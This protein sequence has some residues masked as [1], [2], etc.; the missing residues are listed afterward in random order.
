MKLPYGYVVGTQGADGDGFDV[1]LGPNPVAPYVWVV[2]QARPDRGDTT[3][4]GH[5]MYDESKAFLGFDDPHEVTAAFLEHYDDVRFFGS[6]EQMPVSEFKTKV[7]STT[8]Y[9]KDGVLKSASASAATSGKLLRPEILLTAQVQKASLHPILAFEP[10]ADRLP[11]VAASGLNI[12]LGVPSRPT[13]QDPD[14]ARRHDPSSMRAGL[15]IQSR[16]RGAAI[17]SAIRRDPET[18][19]IRPITPAIVKPMTPWDGRAELGEAARDDA[20]DHLALVEDMLERRSDVIQNAAPT[21]LYPRDTRLVVSSKSLASP[22]TIKADSASTTDDLSLASGHLAA[23]DKPG[24]GLVVLR[25]SGDEFVVEMPESSRRFASLSS[26]CDHVWVLQRGYT[27][28]DAWRAATG[29]RKVPSGA[30]WKFWGLR[31]EGV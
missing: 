8:S 6:L 5:A 7:A 22:N 27:D 18:Y 1:F 2:H 31:P 12:A 29:K 9:N 26:A 20:V 25:K 23:I 17:E 28:V 11:G 10:A 15:E 19:A 30:G 16:D 3:Y 4:D 21:K 24:L 13:D 14:K